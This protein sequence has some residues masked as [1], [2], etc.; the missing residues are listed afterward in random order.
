MRH[1]FPKTVL[2]VHVERAKFYQPRMPRAVSRRNSPVRYH[3]D[4][5]GQRKGVV[6]P[7][8]LVEVLRADPSG[9]NVSRPTTGLQNGQYQAGLSVGTNHF[10]SGVFFLLD[11]PVPGTVRTRKELLYHISR[12][13]SKMCLRKANMYQVSSI[14]HPKLIPF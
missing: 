4:R 12:K 1:L 11:E 5:H 8:L 3:T 2:L 7:V 14:E 9:E 6:Q 13:H 10:F